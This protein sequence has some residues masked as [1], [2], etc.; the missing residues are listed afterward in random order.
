MHSH[1]IACM[2]AC[3]YEHCHK[4]MTPKV[5]SHLCKKKI[6]VSSVM[7]SIGSSLLCIKFDCANKFDQKCLP[8][9]VYIRL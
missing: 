9:N 8:F 7:K 3:M 5:S 2:L 4:K 6:M 1:N